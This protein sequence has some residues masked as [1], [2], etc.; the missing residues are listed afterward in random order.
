MS[1]DFESIKTTLRDEIP[2]EIKTALNK[3]TKILLDELK[4]EDKNIKGLALET[5]AVR[6]AMDIGLEP[7][8]LRERST[9]TGGAEIDLIADGVSLHYS[10]WLCQCKNTETVSLADLAKEVG[11]ATLLKAHVVL[12]I[13]TGTYASTV[14]EYA[15]ELSSGTPLQAILITG[16]QLREWSEKGPRPLLA[17]L[18]CDA[19]ACR[20]LKR[21]Q[22]F[23]QPVTPT[24]TE[25]S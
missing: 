21:S 5:I 3:N 25:Q 1:F 22:V 14:V 20:E 16:E 10:R 24:G 9:I 8:R 15:N 18:F 6:I 13:T 4:S 11:M 17:K 23:G 7:M 2:P 12:M 19:E